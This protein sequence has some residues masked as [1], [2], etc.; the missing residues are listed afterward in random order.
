MDYRNE[1]GHP[2]V[3]VVRRIDM[4]DGETTFNM[5]EPCGDDA[6]ESGVFV[7]EYELCEG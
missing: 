6:L 1:C 4:D 3:M 7:E 2:S 5:C